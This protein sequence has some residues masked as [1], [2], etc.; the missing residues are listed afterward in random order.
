M[1]EGSLCPLRWRF[2]TASTATGIS[3]AAG[4]M[5]ALVLASPLVACG[6]DVSTASVVTVSET[7]IEF[8]AVVTAAGFDEESDMAGYHFIVWHDGRA[9]SRSL[10][11]SEVSDVRVLDAIEALGAEPGN[12]LSIDTW[13]E[14]HDP[15]STAPD[16]LIEGPLVNL[17]VIVPGRSEALRLEDI[18]LDPGRRGFDM[19]FGGHRE[20][21]DQWHSGCIVCLYSCPGSKIG[22]A[23]YTVREFV[24]GATRFRVQPGAL[25]EDGTEVTIRV[26]LANRPGEAR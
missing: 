24:D 8:P 9:A 3:I 12:A 18:L 20:N 16:K 15:D 6:Q 14:R 19:R 1:R 2:V 11:R 10:F 25:P 23:S 5:V 26:E 22:N 7:S 13:D 17:Y 4:V 21:I